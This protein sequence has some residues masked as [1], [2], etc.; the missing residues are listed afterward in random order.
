MVCA[1]DLEPGLSPIEASP[2]W[3]RF[4]RDSPK[5]ITSFFDS[6]R[7]SSSVSHMREGVWGGCGMQCRR[8]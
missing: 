3:I 1:S 8:S 7:F 5:G 2:C 6:L 4:G